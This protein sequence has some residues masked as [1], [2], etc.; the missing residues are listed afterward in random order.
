MRVLL[1]STSE[2]GKRT[3]YV[4]LAEGD[5]DFVGVWNAPGTRRTQRSGTASDVDGFDIAVTDRSRANH[6]LIARCSVAGIPIVLWADDA[7]IAPGAATVPIVTGANVGSAL[8]AA[9]LAHPNANPAPGEPVT[10]A[11][12]EPGKPR[13]RGE[14][15]V[16]PE[17]V[18]A[19]R[20]KRR[21]GGQLVATRDDEWAGAVVRVGSDDAIRVVGAADHAGHLE[22]LVLA[23]TAL[24]A[25]AGVYAPGTRSAAEAGEQLLNMLRRV[26]LDFATWRSHP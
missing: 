14:D 26:E 25:A 11:W 10:V 1:E 15:V 2:V 7:D 8:I 16:F 13:R 12:T 20:A 19:M 18:G 24:V 22:A 4:L 21:A 9:L 23:A 5:V 6:D 17:P 3:A